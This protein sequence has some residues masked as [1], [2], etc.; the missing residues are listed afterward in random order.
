MYT[1]L[2]SLMWIEQTTQFFKNSGKLRDTVSVDDHY[3]LLNTKAFGGIKKF[4]FSGCRSGS[5][6][7]EKLC[8][9]AKKNG[10][11]VVVDDTVS[12]SFVGEVFPSYVA[13]NSERARFLKNN[14]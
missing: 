6:F 8:E 1:H 13:L 3:V 5:G 12:C 11:R 4:D 9:I 2:R 10:Y 14:E 7:V